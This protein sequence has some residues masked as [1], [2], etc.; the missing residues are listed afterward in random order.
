MWPAKFSPRLEPDFL[1]HL[2]ELR[3]RLIVS[4]A[5]FFLFSIFSYFFS[6][7]LLD[8]LT[9]PLNQFQQAQL[10]FQTPYE[11]F[12]THLKVAAFAGFLLSSPILLTQGWFFVAPGLYPR[13]K[14]IFLPLILVTCLLF[15]VGALFAYLVV[16][17]WG[18]HFLLSFQTESLKPLLGISPYFSFLAGMVLAFGFVFDFPIVIISLVRL[19]IINTKKL[20]NARKG[21]IVFL[22]FLAAVLTP[23]PDPISQLLLA[24]PLIFLFEIS[25]FA[26]RRMEKTRLKNEP[27][28]SHHKNLR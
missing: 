19:E 15:L 10:F 28:P 12:L 9:L 24:F 14:K 25:I 16:V 1:S 6:K 20:A 21:I 26:A 2:E 23:S 4:L 27:N 3:R 17:P 11:A 8:F 5:A 13:E 18:L 22:F 7:Q